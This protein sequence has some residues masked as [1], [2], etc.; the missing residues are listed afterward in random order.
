MPL[1]YFPFRNETALEQAALEQ[2]ARNAP[3]LNY[4]AP[5]AGCPTRP[6]WRGERIRVLP[7]A[8]R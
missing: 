6:A 7:G 4:G 8:K 3:V 2:A 1:R 5:G